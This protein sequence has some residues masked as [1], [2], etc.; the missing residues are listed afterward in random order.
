MIVRKYLF[1]KCEEGIRTY[2]VTKEGEFNVLKP[3]GRDVFTDGKWNEFFKW[4]NKSAAITDDEFIDFCFLVDKKSDL[5]LSDLDY[6]LNTKSSWDK[7][8]ICLFIEKNINAELFEVFYSDEECF[9]VQNGNIFDD[10]NVKK[11]FLKCMPEFSMETKEVNDVGSEETSVV[12]RYFM[13]LL[14][15]I[16]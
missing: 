16:R 10:K 14:N 13:D 15:E 4:F 8:E 5:P 2:K 1:W 7:K 12:N 9:V 11:M 3:S 6:T